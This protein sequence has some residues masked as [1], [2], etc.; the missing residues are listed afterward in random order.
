MKK[1][2]NEICEEEKRKTMKWIGEN[3]RD[4]EIVMIEEILRSYSTL[5]ILDM[6]CDLEKKVIR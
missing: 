1:Q 5:S 3:I 6:S 2:R 4:E